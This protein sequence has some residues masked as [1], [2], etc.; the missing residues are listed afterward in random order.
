MSRPALPALLGLALA[1][2]LAGEA[3]SQEPVGAADVGA[4]DIE[5]T[6]EARGA[7][8][9]EERYLVAPFPEAVELRLLTRPCAGVGSVRVWRSGVAV[10][11]LQERDGPWLVVRD[12]TAT[13]GD[14]LDL[15]VRYEVRGRGIEPDIPLLLLTTPI[16]QE[17]GERQGTVRVRVRL[18]DASGRVVF[19]HMTR[20]A[21]AEWEARY[22][23]IPSF[24]Q[25]SLGGGE[26]AATGACAPE[27]TPSGSD[28]GLVW[29]F[30]LLVG[31]M[32]AWVPLY[33]AWA[34]RSGDDGE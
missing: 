26:G 23:A 24:V 10:P 33:L 11:A 18:P 30:L 1:A 14:T 2:A 17:D 19:P 15:Q 3:R 13:A 6:V 16:P 34:R 8:R 7:A 28:G 27:G 25:L 29:R 31:I 12:T 22:V 21:P 32:G 20:Q 4:V 9:V 5:V